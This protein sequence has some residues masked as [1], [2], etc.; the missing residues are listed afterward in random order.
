[1]TE[2]QEFK[3]FFRRMGV[4]F[5]SVS[6]DKETAKEWAN[7]KLKYYPKE[8]TEAEILRRTFYMLTVVQTHF[9]FDELEMYIGIWIEEIGYV[10]G[11]LI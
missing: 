4:I 1:M 2:M 7:R 5:S 3:A 6:V 10:S 9:L 8:T 11:R